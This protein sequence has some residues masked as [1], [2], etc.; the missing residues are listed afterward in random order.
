MCPSLGYPHGLWHKTSFYKPFTRQYIY[1]SYTIGETL[2]GE[3]TKDALLPIHLLKILNIYSSSDNPLTR[4]QLIELY[5]TYYGGKLNR[6]S[7][8]RY[9]DGLIS[10]DYIKNAMQ[11]GIFF[12]RSFDEKQIRYLIDGVMYGQHVPVN[13]ANELIAKLMDMA[14]SSMNE[15]FKN[16]YYIENYNQTANKS[17]NNIIDELDKA[18]TLDCMVEIVLGSFDINREIINTV[19]SYVISPYYL[20]S[21]MTH[22]YILCHLEDKSD[23][24]EEQR[25]I[26]AIR[27]DQ[28]RSARI[29]KNSPRLSLEDCFKDGKQFELS[30]YIKEHIYIYPGNSVRAQVLINRNSISEFIDYFGLEFEILTENGNN[31]LLKIVVNKMALVYWALQ[32]A[33]IATVLGPREVKEEIIDYLDKNLKRYKQNYGNH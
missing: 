21:Q 8:R 11:K 17:I 3:Y 13:E 33:N 30:E 2:M 16:F 31:V 12:N 6:T 18:I 29:R 26:T 22:Y 7:L 4:Q 5:E 10:E 24:S 19:Q 28:I 20:I 25:N 23:S 32:N 14:G 9:L 15:K 27:I 1:S